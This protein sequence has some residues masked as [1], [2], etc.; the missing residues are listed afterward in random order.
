ML[1]LFF[2]ST[3]DQKDNL[4][5]LSNVFEIRGKEHSKVRCLKKLRGLRAPLI[6]SPR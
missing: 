4:F 2:K 5:F 1:K 3:I 6:A